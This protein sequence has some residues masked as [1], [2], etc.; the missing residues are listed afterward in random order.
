MRSYFLKSKDE[1]SLAMR[2][3]AKEAFEN[4]FN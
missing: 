2:Q 3:A 4:N 1:C